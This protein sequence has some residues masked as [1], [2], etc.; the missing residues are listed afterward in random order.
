MT[1]IVGNDEHLF[2][3]LFIQVRTVTSVTVAD[4]HQDPQ[5]ESIEH[6]LPHDGPHLD[7]LHSN[8]PRFLE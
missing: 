2:Q 6:D 7:L 4:H 3:T 8:F 1:C 5:K